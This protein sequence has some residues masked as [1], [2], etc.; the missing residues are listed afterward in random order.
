MISFARSILFAAMTVIA[1]CGTVA[2]AEITVAVAEFDYTDTSGEARDQTADH[3]ARLKAFAE[4][5]RSGLANGGGKYRVVKLDCPE[6]ACSAG[7]TDSTELI[8]M[9]RKSGAR[10][11]IYGGAHKMSTLVQNGLM[12]VVDLQT[13]RLLLDRRITFR[14]DNDEAWSR[15]REFLT[16]ELMALEL[17]Q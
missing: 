10:L 8:A 3:A 1:I 7:N 12:Q 13:G 2:A 16:K 6:T 9:A 15:A 14:G 11:L 5:I 17:T 4:G